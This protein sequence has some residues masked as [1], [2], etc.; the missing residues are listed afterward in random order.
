MIWLKSY[1]P[2]ERRCCQ[3]DLVRNEG[4]GIRPCVG[5]ASLPRRAEGHANVFAR[6]VLAKFSLPLQLNI[7]CLTNCLAFINMLAI[8]LRLS[9]MGCE[10]FYLRKSIIVPH[11][12]L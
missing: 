12:Q 5:P 10:V 6:P 7:V 11:I 4:F 9:K 8:I 1:D 2:E 3:K